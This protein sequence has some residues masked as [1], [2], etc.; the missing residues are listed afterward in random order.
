MI[1]R[2]LSLVLVGL[3]SPFL[4]GA[5]AKLALPLRANSARLRRENR[6][7]DDPSSS[8]QQ[9]RSS[10][11]RIKNVAPLPSLLE[12]VPRS[13][14]EVVAKPSAP[15]SAQPPAPIAELKKPKTIVGQ[16]DVVI[17]DKK[18]SWVPNFLTW[19][20]G[21]EPQPL[22][23]SLAW[24]EEKGKDEDDHGHH[25]LADLEAKSAMPNK[26]ESPGRPLH[27]VAR[28][29]RFGPPAEG[30]T[31]DEDDLIKDSNPAK[32]D[33]PE[34]GVEGEQPR[35]FSFMSLIYLMVL[36]AAIILCCVLC[37]EAMCHICC[38]M[39]IGKVNA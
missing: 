31:L 30:N 27:F 4:G 32:S 25:V 5:A 8:L 28:G 18:P 16:S 26:A 19:L 1:M 14:A 39:C 36:L 7:A 10:S 3:L 35:G 9:L 13:K 12:D 24:L 21:G 17:D 38:A 11:P 34:G 23:N 22:R 33:H 20:R 37:P 15:L 2:G 29:G 6:A